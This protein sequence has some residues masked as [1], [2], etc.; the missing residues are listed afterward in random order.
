[1]R[2]GPLWAS[3]LRGTH[4]LR[5]G[6]PNLRLVLAFSLVSARLA[7]GQA[8]GA[9]VLS[10]MPGVYGRVPSAGQRCQQRQVRATRGAER[11]VRI[12]QRPLPGNSGA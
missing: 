12:F 5:A 7:Q 6:R 10:A 8:G 1:M 4:R 9:D 3:D 11:Q 2:G